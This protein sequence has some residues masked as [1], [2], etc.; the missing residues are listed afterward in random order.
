MD[1]VSEATGVLTTVV[2]D[3][4]EMLFVGLGLIFGLVAV[5]VGLFFAIRQLK[6][7]IGRAK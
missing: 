6:K 3:V 4:G 2:G 5:L 1:Y 7:W